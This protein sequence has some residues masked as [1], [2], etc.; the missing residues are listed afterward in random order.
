MTTRHRRVAATSMTRILPILLL[1][2]VAFT[3]TAQAHVCVG[4]SCGCSIGPGH[5]HTGP[6]CLTAALPDGGPPTEAPATLEVPQ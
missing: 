3:A 2:L 5:V 4:D 1:A 6:A